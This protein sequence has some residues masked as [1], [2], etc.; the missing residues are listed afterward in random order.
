[1]LQNVPLLDRW[2]SFDRLTSLSLSLTGSVGPHLIV[3]LLCLGDLD[4]RRDRHGIELLE[5]LVEH[6]HVSSE[7]R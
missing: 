6:V 3:L 2:A 4:K 5:G 7:T 1:M